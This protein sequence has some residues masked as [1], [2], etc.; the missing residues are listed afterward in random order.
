[1]NTTTP[2][3]SLSEDHCETVD[4]GYRFFGIN[5]HGGVGGWAVAGVPGAG[6]FPL[7][8][9]NGKVIVDVE[10]NASNE[11]VGAHKVL[12][13]GILRVELLSLSGG[14]ARLRATAIGKAKTDSGKSVD[15]QVAFNITTNAPS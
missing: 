13:D 3:S 6:E 12:S 10:M 4:G 8:G 2:A 5:N 1:M 15:V 11:T 14:K 9:E 7:T